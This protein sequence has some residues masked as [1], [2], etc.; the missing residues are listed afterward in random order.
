MKYLEEF[1]QP[2]RV[3]QVA[4]SIA[5]L[6][7]PPARLME[8]CGTHTMAIARGGLR[9]LLPA[10]IELCSGPGCPVCVT[11]QPDIDRFIAMGV[12]GHTLATF[13]DMM[14]VPGTTASL[15]E[16]RAAG[17][18]VRVVYS[19]LDAVELAGGAT[20]QVIFFGVG[21]ET[22]APAVALAIQQAQREDLRNFSVLSA[23]K[24]IPPALH[25]LL[26]SDVRIDGFLCPGHVSVIIGSDA[27][28]PVADGG[29]PCVIAGFEPLDILQAVL[30]L[31]QQVQ[32]GESRVEVQYSRVVTAAGNVKAQALLAEI[33]EPADVRWRGLGAA[34]SSARNYATS[35]PP[36]VF[37]SKCRR[38]G[39]PAASAVT[40][41]AAPSRRRSAPTS[42][43]T[44][45]PA[46]PSARAWCHRRAL[47]PP[48][49]ATAP[50]SFRRERRAH[51]ARPR[52]RRTA[53]VRADRPRFSRSLRPPPL[54][55]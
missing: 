15:E 32:R 21:F 24:L 25:A 18:D 35:T 54:P 29:V 50:R 5:R 12:P 3:R 53:Y 6:K 30:R 9:G 37:P 45:R 49:I 40:S 55:R 7:P 31:V 36:I 16:A 13:G 44:A 41:C 19:P 2:D 23:H 11:D 51:P 39:R 52:Q 42:E 48:T 4:D 17:A 20:N 8:V 10:G 33:F 34:S 43:T 22:T 27:Y 46:P 1:R 14:R 47:A 38:R 28:R 26:G